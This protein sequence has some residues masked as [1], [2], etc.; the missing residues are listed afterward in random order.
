MGQLIMEGAMAV[1]A[2][3]IFNLES[4]LVARKNIVTASEQSDRVPGKNNQENFFKL[5]LNY[6]NLKQD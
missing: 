6:L 4:L 5:P 2:G 1:W 3:V